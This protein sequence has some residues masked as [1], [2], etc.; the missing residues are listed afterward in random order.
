MTARWDDDCK[1]LCVTLLNDVRLYC[2]DNLSFN[3]FKLLAAVEMF[4]FTLKYIINSRT[5]N[6]QDAI[7][8]FEEQLLRY[9][10]EVRL[11]YYSRRFVI[12]IVYMQF[13]KI[14]PQHPPKSLEV[15]SIDE[16]FKLLQLFERLV[17][18]HL[19]LLRAIT[20]HNCT[21]EL[22]IAPDEMFM[23]KGKW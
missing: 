16:S 22:K 15:F 20:A 12:N 23:K 3:N 17:L 6:T 2:D 8:F 1:W 19:V 4:F 5:A 9:S 13:G 14:H 21:V 10:V 18:S 7:D 11:F